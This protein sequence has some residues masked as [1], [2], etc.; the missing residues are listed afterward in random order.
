MTAL[1]A[2]DPA[3]FSLPEN[4]TER[5]QTMTSVPAS[6]VEYG[7]RRT[8]VVIA[9]MLAV[10][11]EILDTT[12][13]NVAL[14]TLQGNMGL[15]F[16]QASWIVTGY[17]IA[18]IIALPLVPWLESVF[19]RK[20]YCVYAIAGFTLASAACGAAQSY[21]S[22]VVFR[23]LQGL[24]GGG[25]LTVARSI[26]RDTFPPEDLGKSQALLSLG[27]VVGPSIGPTVGG[28][29][30]DAFSWR[31]IFFINLVPGIVSATLLW[32]A[33]REPKRER[34]STDGIGLLLLVV[35]LGSLQFV[36]ENGERYDWFD[37]ARIAMCAALA[38]AC[39]AA[40]GVW[41]WFGAKHPIVDLKILRRPAVAM[42]SVLSFGLGFTLF[43][44]IVLGPQ[45]NQGILG[46]TATLSGNQVLIRALA[47]ASFIPIAVISLARLRIEPRWLLATGFALIGIAGLWMAEVTTTTADFWSFGWPLAVGGFGFGLIF[48]PLSVAV[49]S[50]VSGPETSKASSMLSLSQQLGA[51]FATAVLVTTI[52]RRSALHL[53]TL[54]ATITARHVANFATS[55]VHASVRELASLVRRQAITLGFADANVL[56]GIAAFAMV[57]IA[58]A[59][60]RRAPAPPT[61]P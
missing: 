56:G 28:I 36:L 14:P 42:G 1:A 27:A 23:V 29:L 11:L 57:P 10:L 15:D 34:V 24:C 39:T 47:I 33:L 25:I 6:L 2:D 22:L 52:D 35:G 48:V 60:W 46:F 16:D 32:F 43:I 21:E 4:A 7:M 40:F 12:I 5:S 58:L 54:A 9:I 3:S 51:S 49:L 53:D 8:L 13:V 44:G 59:F 17:L 18:V 61:R 38:A 41:E 30:T 50:A 31:W 26:L 19:G 37:D 45:F 20:R 55:T